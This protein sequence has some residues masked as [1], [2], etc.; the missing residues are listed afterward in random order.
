MSALHETARRILA[1]HREAG[2]PEAERAR[3]VVTAHLESLGYRVTVQRFSFHPS[4]L[5]GFPILGAGVGAASLLALPLLHLPTVAGL[6]RA[7]RLAHDP[8][9]I[10]LSRRERRGGLARVRRDAG[11]RQPDRGQIQ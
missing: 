1:D 7:A 6:G 9:R 8:R 4:A 11:G 10:G 2:T 3:A 5:L